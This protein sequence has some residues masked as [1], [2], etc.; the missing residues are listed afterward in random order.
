MSEADNIVRKLLEDDELDP[1]DYI[2][3]R[4][5]WI[6]F[7]DFTPGSFNELPKTSGYYCYFHLPRVDDAD[8]PEGQYH[9]EGGWDNL[10]DAAHFYDSECGDRAKIIILDAPN[11][12]AKV[13]PYVRHTDFNSDPNGPKAG[14]IESV[15]RFLRGE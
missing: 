10:E 1:K 6:E 7:P 5:M 4:G 12:R 9:F 3:Q 15:E 8:P 2:D 13:V 14:H 11:R